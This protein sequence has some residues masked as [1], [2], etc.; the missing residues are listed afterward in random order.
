M[1]SHWFVKCQQKA[2][3]SCLTSLDQNFTVHCHWNNLYESLLKDH[4]SQSQY[5]PH[6]LGHN[7]EEKKKKIINDL[8]LMHVFHSDDLQKVYCLILCRAPT[9]MQITTGDE[10]IQMFL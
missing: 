6:M 4:L 1:K 3:Y 7:S 9:V 5:L 8:K 2:F 10:D